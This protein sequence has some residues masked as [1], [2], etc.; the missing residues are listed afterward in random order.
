MR[1]HNYNEW[2]EFWQRNPSLFYETYFG[3]KLNPYQK[4]MLKIILKNGERY[5]KI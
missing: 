1:Y 2:K 3:I 4:L 5:E